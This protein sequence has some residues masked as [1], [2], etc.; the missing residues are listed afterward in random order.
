MMFRLATDNNFSA[1]VGYF[2]PLGRASTK[3]IPSMMP[4]PFSLRRRL[5]Q[6]A[7]SCTA[8]S[9]R[10]AM[11]R[12]P[13]VKGDN[14]VARMLAHTLLGARGKFSVIVHSP[15]LYSCLLLFVLPAYAWAAA[16][17][18]PVLPTGVRWAQ[19]CTTC[20]LTDKC[21]RMESSRVQECIRQKL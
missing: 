16:C 19:F 1:L 10:H 20:S 2:P 11:S 8:S 5:P 3:S 6:T 14:G 17:S 9:P 12:R 4:I 21:R 13:F 7:F 18:L 15:P